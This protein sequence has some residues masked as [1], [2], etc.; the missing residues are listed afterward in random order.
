M[1][2]ALFRAI[3]L[4]P[5]GA[6]S[7]LASEGSPLLISPQILRECLAAVTR[8]QATAP[9]LPMATAI[10]NVRRFRTTFQIAVERPGLV[11]RLIHLLATHRAV[12]RQ[13][14]DANIVATMLDHGIQRLVTFNIADFQ[15][16]AGL[17][18]ILLP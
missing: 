3:T 6:L 13:V 17:I 2:R 10:A 11:D 14:H 7:R 12:G 18:D 5:N 8:P 4:R 9:A 1:P 16:F 15:R